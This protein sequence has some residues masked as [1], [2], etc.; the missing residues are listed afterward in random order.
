MQIENIGEMLT[1]REE[2]KSHA[3]HCAFIQLG[4]KEDQLTYQDMR[5]LELSRHINSIVSTYKQFSLGHRAEWSAIIVRAPIRPLSPSFCPY[6]TF[7][8]KSF[9][10]CCVA[11]YLCSR[12]LASHIY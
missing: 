11:K 5:Q 10:P 4:K 2:H 7:A 1:C 9:L 6:I 12:C 3:A 8:Y